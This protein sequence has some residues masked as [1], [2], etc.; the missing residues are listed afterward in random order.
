MYYT[1]GPIPEIVTASCAIPGLFN[2]IQ[3]D[4]K[5][6]VDGGVFDNLPVST[7]EDLPIIASHVNPR[8]RD[9]DNPL[10]DISLRSLEMMVARDITDQSKKCDIFIEPP[11]IAKF[12]FGL[13]V[14]A[15]KFIDVGYDHTIKLLR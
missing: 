5:V 7:A 10:K 8:M 1:S 14:K 15:Q 3:Y 12:G 13:G 9:E 11:A 2:A 6:L 4:D